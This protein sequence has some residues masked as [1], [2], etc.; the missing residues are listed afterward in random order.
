[1]TDPRLVVAWLLLLHLVAE[2]LF[3]P[4]PG[5]GRP[6]LA[7]VAIHG[8]AVAVC[9]APVAAAFGAPGAAVAVVAVLAHLVL[10]GLEPGARPAL[11]ARPDAD[12]SAPSDLSLGPAWTI[13]PAAW[14]ALCQGL[15]VVILVAA[16]RVFLADAAPTQLVVDLARNATGA[17]AP[18]DFH[19][20]VLVAV[21]GAGILIVDVVAAARFV[22]LL[23]RP[24]GRPAR[25][26]GAAGAPAPAEAPEAAPTRGWR[27]QLG[28]LTGSVVP[29]PAVAQ[30]AS[31]AAPGGGATAAATVGRAIGIFERLL[32]T[33][34]VLA[35]AEAAVALVVGVKTVARYRQLDDRSFAEYYLLGTLASVSIGIGAG[36]LAR[37]ALA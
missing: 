33:M 31:Q 9:F 11:E 15:H 22:G 24:W 34:L 28:P 16:W 20:A 12:G 7:R 4:E 8:L 26:G 27:I 13:R 29:E 14:A 32:I 1:M 37:V 17:A 25:P 5:R 18:A 21:V 10:D 36:L 3:R 2:Y 23:L 30:P 19:R 35:Q 6:P